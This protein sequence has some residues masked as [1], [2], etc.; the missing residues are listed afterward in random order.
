MHGNYD[1]NRGRWFTSFT[2]R[3]FRSAAKIPDQRAAANDGDKD[4]ERD[5]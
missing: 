1:G 2:T 5:D 3:E 4:D